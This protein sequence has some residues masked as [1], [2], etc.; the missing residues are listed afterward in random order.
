MSNFTC[1]QALQY[2]KLEHPLIGKVIRKSIF[3][4]LLRKTVLFVV[5]PTILSL[6][7]M[8]RQT[9]LPSLF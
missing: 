2:M 6:E 5:Y 4:I 1:L 9:L 8:K 3:K 7:A